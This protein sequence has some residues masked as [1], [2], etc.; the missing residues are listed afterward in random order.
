MRVARGLAP[1]EGDLFAPQNPSAA[2]FG[3]N[4]DTHEPHGSRGGPGQQ[5]PPDGGQHLQQRQGRRPR[6]H[7]AASHSDRD[8]VA[9]D[10]VMLVEMC[11]RL[12]V[13]V[14]VCKRAH[15]CKCARAYVCMHV[16]RTTR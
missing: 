7:S 12:R 1:L 11:A 9:Y 15:E 16:L 14:Y 5:E 10:Q 2:G 4:P 8:S 3:P 13:C 6:V